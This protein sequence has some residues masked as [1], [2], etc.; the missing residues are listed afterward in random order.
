MNNNI[1]TQ[2][3][4]E[5]V[6]EQGRSLKYLCDR[7]GVKSRTYFQDVE[8]QGRN[9]PVKKLEIIADALDTT[10]D[11][12]LGETDVKTKITEKMKGVICVNTPTTIKEI[13]ETYNISQT[14]LSR[15]FGI[16]LR[17]V[18]G[19]CAGERKPP[20]YIVNMIAEILRKE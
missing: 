3:I 19:W 16:P 18:Q 7:I 4:R 10:T 2:R 14:Q 8:K 5:L 6:D 17:T 13:C 20:A 11:Y 12:L 15:R 1:T 9:I